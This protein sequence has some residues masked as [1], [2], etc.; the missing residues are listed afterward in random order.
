[1]RRWRLNREAPMR[2]ALCLV[3]ALTLA[4]CGQSAAAPPSAQGPA[5]AAAAAPAA[6]PPL[7]RIRVAYAAPVGVFATPWAAKEAGLVET[8]G[9]DAEVAYVANGPTL[10]KSMLAGEIQFGELAAPSSMSA[11]VESGEAVWIANV[12]NRPVL[13]LLAAPEVARIDDLRDRPVG[14]TRIGTTTHTM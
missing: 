4:A 8:D 9:L 13:Y 1:G 12:I 14:V 10:I 7:E 11:Y 6:P 5:S 2:L 3:V